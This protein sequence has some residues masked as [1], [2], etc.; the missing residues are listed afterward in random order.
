MIG[1]NLIYW[2][3]GFLSSEV[4]FV[5]VFSVGYIIFALYVTYSLIIGIL[6]FKKVGVVSGIEDVHRSHIAK[7]VD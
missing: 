3:H 4:A 2:K 1:K 6:S 5:K 7:E